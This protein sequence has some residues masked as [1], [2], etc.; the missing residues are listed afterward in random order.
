MRRLRAFFVRLLGLV[1]S[2]RR[3]GEPDDELASHLQFHIEDNVRAGMTPAEARRKA[4]LA[5]GGIEQTKEVYR[6]R[7]H[8]PVVD[9]LSRDLRYATRQLLTHPSFALTT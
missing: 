8:L 9:T 4:R 3:G 2:S 1:T 6:E 5:L 7:Q